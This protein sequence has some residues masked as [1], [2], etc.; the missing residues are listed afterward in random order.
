MALLWYFRGVCAVFP[1][2]NAQVPG[3]L[4]PGH[5]LPLEGKEKVLGSS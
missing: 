5:L 2:K 3:V 4:H 1:L